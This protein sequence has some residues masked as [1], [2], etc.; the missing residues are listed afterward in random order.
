[1]AVNKKGTL[2]GRGAERARRERAWVKLSRVLAAAGALAAEIEEFRD[3]DDA[4]ALLADDGVANELRQ[5]A[6]ATHTTS[7]DL[8]ALA[9]VAVH[10]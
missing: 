5:L 4:A 8:A 2:A 3:D 7:T 1:M 10:D 6:Y 9:A